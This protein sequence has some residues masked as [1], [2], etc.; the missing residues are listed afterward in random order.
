MAPISCRCRASGPQ[1]AQHVHAR[2]AA[3]ALAKFVT[4]V[5]LPTVGQRI[6]FPHASAEV[7]SPPPKQSAPWKPSLDSRSRVSISKRCD[8]GIQQVSRGSPRTAAG[9]P[10]LVNVPELRPR[11]RR[12]RAGR[13]DQDLRVHA[14]PSA[15]R[16]Q[17]QSHD[18]GPSHPAR[19]ARSPSE[20]PVRKSARA[21]Q[22]A[23]AVKQSAAPGCQC[24]PLPSIAVPRST[25]PRLGVHLPPLTA[26][27]RP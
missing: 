15:D 25:R 21:A 22:L 9:E 8:A 4:A 24:R 12:V 13:H 5:H 3:T 19:T 17:Q 27:D 1:R 10:H 7:T 11:G 6:V 2:P 14:L 23:S 20:S 16:D 18:H 26:E